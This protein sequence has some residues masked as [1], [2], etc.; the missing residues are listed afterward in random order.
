MRYALSESEWRSIRPI[1]PSK[2][3]GIPRVPEARGNPA[4]ANRS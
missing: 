2:T 4:V 3:Y 1:L